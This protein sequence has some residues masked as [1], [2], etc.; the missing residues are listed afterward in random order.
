MTQSTYQ[1][2]ETGISENN[3]KHWGELHVVKEFLQNAVYAKAILGDNI[4]ISYQDGQ[5][6]IS[7]TPS[8]FTKGKLLIGES[9]QADIDGAPGQYGEGMK[10]AM[11]IAR[12]LGLACAVQTNGFT[13]HP[14]LEPSSL[15]ESVNAL[16]F[17]IEEHN[18]QVG[19][20]FRVECKESILKE[21][22]T[23]FAVLQGLDV[24][25]TK[26]DNIL[27]DFKGI[28][29]NGVKITD[30]PALYGYNFTN[31]ELINRDR[32]TVDME[33][34]KKET[35]T[36]L[37]AIESEEV[38]TEIV[39]GILENDGLLES[40]SG[41][42]HT[43]HVSVWKK[44]IKKL[45]GDKV[46]LATGTETDT[47]ARY[48]KFTVLTGLPKVWGNF[49]YMYLDVYPSNQLQETTTAT[50][51][52][53]KATAEENKN[54]GWAKRLVKLYY[55]DYGTVKVSATVTD[56][57]GNPCLGLHDYNTDTTWLKRELLSDKEALFKTLLHETIHRITRASDNTEAFT[58]GWEDATW[59]ILNRGKE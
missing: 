20:Q 35:S 9:A 4:S 23:Y 57:Y 47:K 37:S 54:L 8:G 42:M 31:S 10:V 49:F 56:Q 11:A 38:I 13:V 21:A 1:R 25:R 12:R 26:H 59:G 45:F 3:L 46:A 7:N 33:K 29:S 6:V 55:A 27:T 44:V 30:T 32:S 19:T 51:I 43:S 22:M 15:D 41:I 17:Y 50:N 48:R 36:L 39:Q 18:E 52:H 24:E 16:V 28:Y 34:L 58:R 5:A 2:F 14:E 40:Q 53:K